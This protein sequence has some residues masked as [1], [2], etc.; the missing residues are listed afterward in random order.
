[1]LY[2]HNSAEYLYSVFNVFP[3]DHEWST[4]LSAISNDESMMSSDRPVVAG[5]LFSL[6]YIVI[7]F[8][9]LGATIW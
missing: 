3:I 6:S 2:Y 1:M 4:M 5:Y 7:T 9:A 8:H